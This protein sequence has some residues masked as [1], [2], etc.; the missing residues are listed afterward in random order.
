MV[1][2]AAAG[3]DGRGDHFAVRWHVIQHGVLPR[4][5]GGADQLDRAHRGDAVLGLRIPDVAIMFQD[6]PAT[7]AIVVFGE[8]GGSQEEELAELITSGRITK[9]RPRVHRGK[10][11]KAGTRFSHAGAIIEGNRGTHAG[12]V[13]ALRGPGR[14]LSMRLASCR[15][16]WF[17]SCA[18]TKAGLL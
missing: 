6:D 18:H 4:A 12:K 8:I 3:R 2:A 11:A 15:R 14:W 1:Q 16:R 7:D 9:A 10:A 17:Q 13:A 5:S